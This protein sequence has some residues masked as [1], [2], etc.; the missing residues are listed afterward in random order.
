MT[1]QHRQLT[2]FTSRALPLKR[3]SLMLSP[4]RLKSDV[5]RCSLVIAV[6]WS[7]SLTPATAFGQQHDAPKENASSLGF[8]E[9]AFQAIPPLVE[10]SLR[11][12]QMAGAV[13]CIG[14]R[15]GIAYLQSFGNRQVKPTVIPMTNDT[16]FDLASLTKPLAT[17]L[18]IMQL[19]DSGQVRL[20]DPVRL[21]LPDFGRNGKES[22]TILQLLTH[23]GGLIPDNALSDY[24][25]GPDQAWKNIY[26]LPLSTPAG[27]QF[28][29]T[30]VGFLVLGKV[31]EEVTGKSLDEYTQQ[32]IYSP[33]QLASTGFTPSDE[34][35]MR[36]AATET[37]DGRWIVGE[38]HDPRAYQLEGVA[39]HA[40]LFSSA[41]DLA[42]L[43]R[44]MLNQGMWDGQ[45]VLSPSAIRRMSAPERLPKNQIRGLGWDKLSAYSSNRGEYFSAE[46]FGHGGFTG[47]SLWVDP[48]LDLFVI[49]LS[50]RLHPDGKGSVNRLAGAIGT[51]AAAALEEISEDADAT[52]FPASN[53]K[54]TNRVKTGADALVESQFAA[55]AGKKVGLITN[56]TGRTTNGQSLVMQ[57]AQAP[58]VELAAIFSPEHGFKGQLDQAQIDDGIDPESGCKIYS[59]YGESR[60][61]TEAMLKDLDVLIFDIQDI[62][63]RFYTYI[64]TMGL[65]MEAASEHNLE[66]MVLDRPN[67]LGGI[68][69]AGPVLDLGKESFVGFHPISVQHGMTVGELALMFREELQLS[70]QL[71]IIPC[72][73]WEDRRSLEKTGLPWVPPS[74]NMRRFN[75]ARLYPGIGLLEMTNLSVGRG[76][77]T[78]FE[79]IGA[80]WIDGVA[81]AEHLNHAALPGVAFI[82]VRFTPASSKYQEVECQGVS[83]V[84]TQN[85]RFNSLK[86]G[87]AVAT[88]L[89]D[90]YPNDWETKN[91]ARL[92]GDSLVY[93]AF[94]AGKT[95]EE[96]ETSYQQEL[97]EFQTRRQRHLLYGNR[98]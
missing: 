82:P 26:D 11:E 52:L 16:V 32:N 47:T 40:G 2:D 97:A 77:D 19:V 84:I 55:I 57:F 86:L 71:E 20:R 24:E 42:V 27:T 59:L 48:E 60:K 92:L 64:S 79:W 62:G 76:T 87:W 8:N 69:V 91:Y 51:I 46:A 72:Q 75:A 65:A 17:G 78:P 23:Q 21:Y 96:I 63:T 83:F 39:G 1:L 95:A 36:A 15:D 10:D 66:F 29:Y 4:E 5:R 88:A 74:P 98:E 12:G 49:F 41:E 73:D 93:E 89:R 37:R 80:P 28:K 18:S 85:E 54:H 13:V 14:R 34:V 45:R 58:N 61:P 68:E 35:A 90:L 50:N 6:L 53:P 30:D 56:H 43:C 9:T 33:L 31:V 7:L 44:M 38:V 81:L 70:L 94:Q 3:R 22:V 25:D 67:P